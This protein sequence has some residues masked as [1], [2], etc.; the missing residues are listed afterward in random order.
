MCVNRASTENYFAAD[1]AYT[2]P[3]T[4]VSWS[5]RMQL[6]TL[7]ACP[8]HTCLR[9]MLRVEAG[10][11]GLIG[12]RDAVRR[13]G[14]ARADL[15]HAKLAGEAAGRREAAHGGC[16]GRVQARV[17]REALP[18]KRSRREDGTAAVEA[19]QRQRTSSM[20]TSADL[21]AHPGHNRRWPSTQ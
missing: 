8:G 3:Y 2:Q 1:S 18:C 17:A 14:A 21:T 15:W 13:R 16:A 19:S 12:Q 11:I 20:L 5:W 7:K 9:A 6:C 10:Q 4:T